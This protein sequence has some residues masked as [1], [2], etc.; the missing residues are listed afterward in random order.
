[1]TSPVPKAAS[2]LDALDDAAEVRALA[3]AEIDVATGKVISHDAMRRWLLSWGAPE[4]LP[5]PECE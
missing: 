1:M 4:E 5:P 2:I 3:E